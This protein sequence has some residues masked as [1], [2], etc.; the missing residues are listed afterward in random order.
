[1]KIYQKIKIKKA[2]LIFTMV[3]SFFFFFP[4]K[5]QAAWIPGLDPG[6]DNVLEELRLNIKGIIVGTLK[7][8]GIRTLT[9]QINNFAGGKGGEASFVVNWEDAII[10]QPR[11][12]TIVQMNDYLSK[13]TNGRNS[14]KSYITEGFSGPSNYFADLSN[15]VRTLDAPDLK[16]TYEGDPLQ[17]FDGNNFKKLEEWNS[18]INNRY[19]FKV[20]FDEKERETKE[21]IT[22]ATQTDKIANEG[23]NG[24]Q[25]DGEDNITSPG[26]LSKEMIANAQDLPN[27]VL[28]S[29]ETI[30]EVTSAL[31]SLVI[32]RTFT[33]GFS[34]VQKHL[35]KKESANNR[36][37][38]SEEDSNYTSEEDENSSGN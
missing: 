19:M 23:F 11:N 22:L 5:T 25:G 31:V 10:N 24:V 30:P 16:V 33:Q 9:A 36:S 2:I 15:S 7:Q 34:S 29:A 3:L 13:V 32:N 20:A 26:I 6:I 12:K 18:G 1:M 38:S 14:Y 28:A 8:Q 21:N 27:K 37:E 35:S 4:L 17:M